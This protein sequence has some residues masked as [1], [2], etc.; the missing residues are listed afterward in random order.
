MS[1][2]RGQS[3]LS[4]TVARRCL[5]AC[6]VQCP[7]RRQRLGGSNLILE[8]RWRSWPFAGA[9]VVV[10]G[11]SHA[12]K[13]KTLLA[14]FFFL[15]RRPSCSRVRNVKDAWHV[16]Y[17]AFC[18][19]P[20]RWLSRAR[21]ATQRAAC[22]LLLYCTYC[23]VC[24]CVNGGHGCEQIQAGEHGKCLTCREEVRDAAGAS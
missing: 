15:I 8:K 6:L 9:D 18:S 21:T 7:R 4:L 19:V 23:I 17:R 13:Q 2:F 11:R 20:C 24:V 5:C 14:F 3:L 12:V 10:T 1:R 16:R 22:T